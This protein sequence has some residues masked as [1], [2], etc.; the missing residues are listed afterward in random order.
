[1]ATALAA[2]DIKEF[3]FEWEGKDKTGKVV[4]GEVRSAGELR[5]APH[6]AAKASWSPRSRS[7]A[8]AAVR[9]SSRRTW[10]SSRANWQR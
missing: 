2:R 5:S 8:C 4:R 6:C 3:V 7:A 10:L 9:R 1:M